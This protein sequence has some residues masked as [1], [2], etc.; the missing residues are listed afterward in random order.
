MQSD[1]PKKAIVREMNPNY[2]AR[3]EYDD[4]SS[5]IIDPANKVVRRYKRTGLF[6]GNPKEE[7]LKAGHMN[8][9]NA[10]RAL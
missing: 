2:T 6:L 5:I 9:Y 1:K 4:G 3:I 10:V 8:L 7:T